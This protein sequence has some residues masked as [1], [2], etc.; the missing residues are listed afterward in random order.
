VTAHAE[1]PR[2]A[3]GLILLTVTAGFAAA[4]SGQ[5]LP[6]DGAA[7][8]AGISILEPGKPVPAGANERQPS[9]NPLWAIPLSTLTAT[10]ERPIFLPTRRPPA[11]VIANTRIEAPK[12]VAASQPEQPPRFTL[13]GAV[14]SESESIAVF[15]DQ[16]T[17]GVIRLRTGQN[18]DG[19]ILSSVKGR[20]ATLQRDQKTLV[21][22]LPAPGSL[23]PLAGARALSSAPMPSPASGNGVVMPDPSRG[24][25]YVPHSTPKNGEPDG[26]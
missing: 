14:S 18:H 15:L 22:K 16:A 2:L 7:A 25:P 13:V 20:E 10:R 17:N 26:L 8:G 1:A 6:P 21:L 3:A 12:P 19:W 5:D 24:A 11:P 4:P 9:G 23:P